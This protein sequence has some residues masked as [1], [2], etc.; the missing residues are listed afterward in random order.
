MLILCD[1]AF[2]SQIFPKLMT[3]KIIRMFTAKIRMFIIGIKIDISKYRQIN[4]I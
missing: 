1:K 3:F 4:R 2:L